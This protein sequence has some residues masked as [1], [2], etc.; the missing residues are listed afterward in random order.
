MDAAAVI[1]DAFFLSPYDTSE[2]RDIRWL[3]NGLSRF[4][5]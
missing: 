2:Q 5:F 3:L 4:V 1:K